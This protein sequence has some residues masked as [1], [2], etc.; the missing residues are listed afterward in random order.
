MDDLDPLTI[1]GFLA[2][3]STTESTI[4]E[5]R[6]KLRK[7]EQLLGRPVGTA[8]PRDLATL[9]AKLRTMLSGP[10]YARTLGMFYRAG[11]KPDLAALCAM[12]QRNRVI[13]PDEVL[14]PK[15][16]QAMIVATTTKRN[17]ALIGTLWDTGGRISEVLSANLGEV[18]RSASDDKLPLR[19]RLFFAQTK[20]DEPREA[21]V[22]DTARVLDAWI[23]SH[24]F[25][26]DPE[27]PL[28]ANADGSRLS[29][30]RAWALMVAAARRAKV[31]K[32]VWAHLFRHSRATYLLRIGVSEPN[33]KKLLGW[34]ARS[35]QLGRYGHLVSGD[36]YRAVLRA[37]GLDVPMPETVERITLED[38]SLLPV[39]PVLPSGADRAER[40]RD[41]AE[42]GRIAELLSDPEVRA[43]L[44]R[45]LRASTPATA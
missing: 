17:A 22:T 9:K 3:R 44:T 29:R 40:T 35:T 13:K 20:T 14:T 24:P 21:W 26:D 28:F 23:R 7:C 11:G 6:N 33:V 37:Q 31:G 8:T 16:V 30:K 4:A 38:D 45:R 42:L 32:K 25:A 36:A 39:V 5:Y 18:R 19:F 34:S 27:A 1:E 41:D 10:E 2:R 15:D 43:F 12:K